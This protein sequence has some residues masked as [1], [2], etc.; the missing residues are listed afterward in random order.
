ML[1]YVWDRRRDVDRWRGDVEAAGTLDALL[2]SIL[3]RLMQQ[4]LRLGLGREYVR[5]DRVLRGIRGRVDLTRSI[6]GRLLER[7]QVACR[8]SSYESNAPRNQ[9]VRSVLARLALRGRFGE[10]SAAR[11][12]RT[13]VRR[14]VRDLDDVQI[15]EVDGA[16]IRRQTLGP[17]DSDYRM[18]LTICELVVEDLLPVDGHGH[19]SS[20][21][22]EHDQ[23]ALRKLFEDFVPA[24]L[25][26]HMSGWSV[27][28]QHQR[29][30]PAEHPLL[31]RMVVD[32]VLDEVGGHGR[33]LVDTKF[34]PHALLANQWGDLKFDAGHL[35][36]LYTYLRSQVGR[37]HRD[38][39]ASGLLLYP[40]SNQRLR[41][42]FEVQGHAVLVATVDLAASWR[43]VEEELSAIVDGACS[44][45]KAAAASVGVAAR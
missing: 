41:E 12:L 13:R 26:H 42:W 23:R 29:S 33:V 32:V 22:W 5:V 31:P 8:F 14:L 28:T 45:V 24:F 2:A 11:T 6:R 15:V 40:Q 35:Y 7:G 3:V 34:T 39:A 21:R 37:S 18:M 17:N 10:G 25:R 38:N 9:I 19:R 44:S 20:S 4:R 36:Q 27:A 1:L 30:W 43:D 16:L